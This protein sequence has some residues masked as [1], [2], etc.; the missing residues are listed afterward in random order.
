MYPAHPATTQTCEIDSERFIK[1][2]KIIWDYDAFLGE[3][4]QVVW[5]S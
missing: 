1:R 5:T 3:K 2:V 4:F